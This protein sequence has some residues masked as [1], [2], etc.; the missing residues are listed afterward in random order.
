MD[1]SV[2]KTLFGD[3]NAPAEN[4]GQLWARTIGAAILGAVVALIAAW[5]Y[6]VIT[7]GDFTVGGAVA[8]MVGAGIGAG[9]RDLPAITGGARPE[10]RSWTTT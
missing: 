4:T 8:S 2:W 9:R 10:P 6:A 3:R 5:L 1:N 7:D